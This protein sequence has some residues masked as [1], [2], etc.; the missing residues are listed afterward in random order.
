MW[1]KL[2]TLKQEE[3]LKS[4]ENAYKKA[5]ANTHLRVIV[6]MDSD[7]EICEWNDI[8]GGNAVHESTLNGSSI[9][10]F[11]FCFQC[12][13]SKEILYSKEEMEYKSD[14]LKK[15]LDSIKK[16]YQK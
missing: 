8:A 10:L 6:E 9:E 11:E 2:I 3:I 4:G 15:D 16:Y 14:L 12:L 13:E 7:G 5:L 1:K